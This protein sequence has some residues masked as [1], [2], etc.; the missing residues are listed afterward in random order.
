M[1]RARGG[2]A[3]KVGK[4]MAVE[5]ELAKVCC[6]VSRAICPAILDEYPATAMMFHC[7]TLGS[8]STTR[9]H[10][11]SSPQG[12]ALR[13]GIAGPCSARLRVMSASSGG[14]GRRC[15]SLVS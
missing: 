10:L 9:G 1:F 11:R 7:R 3:S 6:Q 14:S 2:E 12:S 4:A 15:G 5:I 13:R 8:S